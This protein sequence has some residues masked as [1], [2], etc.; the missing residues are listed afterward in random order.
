MD[1]SRKEILEKQIKLKEKKTPKNKVKR[2]V[3]RCDFDI[4][5]SRKQ[6]N[7][8]SDISTADGGSN[9]SSFMTADPLDTL[10]DSPLK[11]RTRIYSVD[12][13]SFENEAHASPGASARPII[14]E[15]PES[16]IQGEFKL[17]KID[18]ETGSTYASSPQITALKQFKP[19]STP[20]SFYH[21][22]NS[23][24]IPYLSLEG[25][26]EQSEEESNQYSN[27][28]EEANSN[29]AEG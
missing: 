12:F 14:E 17:Y 10:G 4:K 29:I 2:R 3:T 25:M 8:P 16:K 6:Q 24:A 28:D 20:K 9:E 1:V 22:Q 13:N 15:E 19:D 11:K 7:R 5:P 26:E 21:Y 23:K 27:I 18:E